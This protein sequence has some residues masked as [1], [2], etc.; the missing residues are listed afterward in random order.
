MAQWQDKAL[1][2]FETMYKTNGGL[3]TMFEGYPLQNRG[4]SHFIHQ[5]DKNI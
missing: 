3:V 4:E 1:I 5:M 2:P